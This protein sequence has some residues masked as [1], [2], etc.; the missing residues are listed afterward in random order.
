MRLSEIEE[1][2]NVEFPEKFQQIYASGAMDWMECDIAEFNENKE[3]YISDPASFLMMDSDCEPLF[4]SEVMESYDR[5]RQ[6]ITWKEDDEKVRLKDD[7]K[8]VPFAQNGA[9]D[10]YC[11]LYEDDN[12]PKVIIY[13]HDDDDT[14][15]IAADSFDE[16]LY[17]VMLSAAAFD[18]DIEG[19][20]WKAHFGFLSNEYADKISNRT[21]ADLTDEYDS[22][23][24][25]PADVWE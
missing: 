21:V 17:L 25:K 18:E 4:F 14:P 23:C 10:L 12:E 5:L 22:I 6:W 24:F 3:K 15:G 1:Y 9:G 11:F 7:I 2:F 16:F 8:L 20:S 13:A 19:D